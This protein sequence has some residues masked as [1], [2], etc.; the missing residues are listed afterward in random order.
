MKKSLFNLY[1][2]KTNTFKDFIVLSVVAV[3]VFFIA[4]YFRVFHH[5]AEWEHQQG[6]RRLDE[7]FTVLIFLSFAFAV[8]SFRRWREL[9]HEIEE[10]ERAEKEILELNKQLEI[11]VEELKFVNN[12]METFIY[13]ISHDLRI[14]LQLIG[15]FSK[16]LLKNHRDKLNQEI[17]KKLD[18]IFVSTRKMENLIEALLDYSKSGRQQ[19]KTNQIDMERLVAEIMEELKEN[20]P[21]RK[22]DFQVQSLPS[23]Y[24]DMSLMNQV[25]TNLISNAI[26]YSKSREVAT[27][28][29]GGRMEGNKNIYYVKDNGVGFDEKQVDR[30][31][32]VFQRLHKDEEFEGTGVGLSIVQR[33]IQRHGGEIW[34]KGKVNEGAEFYF[35]L[36]C[37]DLND[38]V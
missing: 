33:I 28:Q 10:R 2:K 35:S 21:E 37:N 15:G 26:K 12:E 29:I 13:S 31:F 18:I 22:I 6:I 4:V 36:P 11:N 25:F 27:I 9:K 7:I 16:N 38:K 23:A 5:L 14:P 30:I 3:L 8:F 20:Y 32:E 19:L 24:G 17:L 34:A 1:K